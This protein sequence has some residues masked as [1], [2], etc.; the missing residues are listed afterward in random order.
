MALSLRVVAALSRSPTCTRS[1]VSPYRVAA[2]L[3]IAAFEA[4]RVLNVRQLHSYTGCQMLSI[5][6]PSFLL[7]AG[8]RWPHRFYPFPPGP[9]VRP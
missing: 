7:S 2:R 9:H 6:L 4:E 8:T 1:T 3:S 5:V